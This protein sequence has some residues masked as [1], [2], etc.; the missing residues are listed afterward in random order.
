MEMTN[1]YLPGSGGSLK[2]R[3]EDYIASESDQDSSF[4]EEMKTDANFV[5]GFVGSKPGETYYGRALEE[6]KYDIDLEDDVSVLRPK[7]YN[8]IETAIQKR[9]SA[10]FRTRSEPIS[11]RIKSEIVL[12]CVYRHKTSDD[13][14]VRIG[15][16]A[17]VI[18]NIIYEFNVLK[19]ATEKVRKSQ[20]M[21]R[22]K[23]KLR[24]L[25]WLQKFVDE[26]SMKGFTL[27]DVKRHLINNCPDLENVTVQT[28]SRIF[29]NKLNLTYKKLGNT[30]PT[31]I[32]PESKSNLV[33]CLKTIVGL[34]NSGFYV[35]FA[36]EFLINRNIMRSYG[37]WRKGRP[38]RLFRKQI[39][40]KMSFVVAHSFHK[41]EGIVGTKTTFNQT[42]YVRF[43]RDLLRRVRQNQGVE[44]SKVA[45]VVDNWR[46]HKTDYVKR[47]IAKEKAACIFI[48]PYCPEINPWEKLINY[49]K[50]YVKGQ[51]DQKR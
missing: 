18:K 49:I 14:A 46:F 36:Y 44:P 28:L 4:E 25:K 24:H 45:L 13:E 7:S 22:T 21:R 29:K 30:N 50:S 10:M 1:F 38:G 48:P 51:V 26:N 31:K 33:L 17:Q 43:L 37:W 8:E 41:V 2:L 27:C 39:G 15:M 11:K 20:S 6:I 5:L 35:I 19:R 9:G 32:L 23:M 16:D 34:I 47:F 40:F 3:S 42:K 12:N